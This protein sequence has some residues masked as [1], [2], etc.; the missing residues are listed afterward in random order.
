MITNKPVPGISVVPR[1]YL[2][3]GEDPDINLGR[4]PF[5]PPQRKGGKVFCIFHFTHC[6]E[7]YNQDSFMK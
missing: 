7:R 4:R 1:V 3:S 6:A 2:G 5:T